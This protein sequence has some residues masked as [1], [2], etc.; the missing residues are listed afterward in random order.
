MAIHGWAATTSTAAWSD[1]LIEKIK[2]AAARSFRAESAFF[3]L[4]N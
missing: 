3:F 2:A 1:F 4:D